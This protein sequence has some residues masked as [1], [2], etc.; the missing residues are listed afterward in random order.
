[1]THFDL[2][3]GWWLKMCIKESILVIFEGGIEVRSGIFY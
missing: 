2:G 1:M 3:E